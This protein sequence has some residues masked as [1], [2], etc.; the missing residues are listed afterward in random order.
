MIDNRKKTSK[1][2][3]TGI[4]LKKRTIKT[5]EIF[6][7]NQ[8]KLVHL[9]ASIF[10]APY[11]H[12]FSAIVQKMHPWDAIWDKSTLYLVQIKHDNYKNAARTVH[13]KAPN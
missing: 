2:N 11:L 5:C 4:D 3:N 13:S 1:G 12:Q 8:P 6:V 10:M 9:I 7:Y